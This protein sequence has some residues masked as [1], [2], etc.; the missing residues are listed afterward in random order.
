MTLKMDRARRVTS[1]HTRAPFNP[2]VH[3][4]EAARFLDDNVYPA[5]N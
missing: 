2:R 5:L 3:R 1:I 4:A